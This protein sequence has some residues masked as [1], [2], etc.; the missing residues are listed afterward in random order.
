MYTRAMTQS[1]SALAGGFVLLTVG[2]SIALAR[3]P[4]PERATRLPAPASASAPAPSASASAT[5]DGPPRGL[6]GV[7]LARTAADIAPRFEGRV[8]AVHVR[9]GDVVPKDGIIASLD[10]PTL[11]YDLSMAEASAR[12]AEIEAQRAAV[13]LAQAEE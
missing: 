1:R 4:G 2:A 7:V 9:L 10:I 13:E 11:H 3:A 8:R 12:A 6:L 5:P